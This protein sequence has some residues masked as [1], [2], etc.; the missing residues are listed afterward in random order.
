MDACCR[1]FIQTM[2]LTANEYGWL[3]D[4]FSESLKNAARNGSLSLA[5]DY[6]I[7]LDQY[8]S[9]FYKCLIAW[10]AL[11]KSRWKDEKKKLYEIRFSILIE[12]KM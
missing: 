3:S 12:K 4:Y 11:N 10:I 2:V 5:R 9:L 8:S 6:L 7:L 1:F